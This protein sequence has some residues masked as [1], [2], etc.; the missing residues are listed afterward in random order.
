MSRK[1]VLMAGLLS[2]P[3]FAG[4]QFVPL[5]SLQED[6]SFGLFRN[7]TDAALTVDETVYGPGFS[8]L[9][10]D[11]LF[12]GLSNIAVGTP[13]GAL[14]T[15]PFAPDNP[16]WLG[17]YR[18]AGRPWSVFQ[19]IFFSDGPDRTTEVAHGDENVETVGL[20]DHIWFDTVTTTLRRGTPT[21]RLVTQTQF[22]ARIAPINLGAFFAV[23]RLDEVNPARNYVSTEV[24][25]YNTSVPGAVPVVETNYVVTRAETENDR[26]TEVVLG[27]PLFLPTEDPAHLFELELGWTRENLDTSLRV[28]HT[29]PQDPAHPDT[30][31][32]DEFVTDTYRTR[33]FTIA[34]AWTLI[35]P[36]LIGTNQNNRFAVGAGLDVTLHSATVVREELE[37]TY[38]FVPG[39]DATAIPGERHEVV[40]RAV[41]TGMMD[42]GL[43]ADVSH[44]I[45]YEPVD[46]LTYGFTPTLTIRYDRGQTDPHNVRRVVTVERVDNTDDG[47]FDDPADEIVT[48]TETYADSTLTGDRQVVSEIAF[49]F[50][51]PASVRIQPEGWSVG[52][53]L[54]SALSASMTR[55]STTTYQGHLAGERLRVVDGTGQ[56]IS[57]AAA[58]YEVDY[59][60]GRAISHAWSFQADH[61][62]GLHVLLPA[63]ARLDVVVRLANLLEFGSLGVQATVPLN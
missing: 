2:L 25:Q 11:Y 58:I 31:H 3:L 49:G 29:V 61:S 21:E 1:I 36:G 38:L 18:A 8:Q 55:T 17:Y 19:G 7:E 35:F 14:G 44:S 4:A 10:A 62:L 9:D 45:Y 50:A 22:L 6:V 27:L 20:T 23:D 56:V 30:S 33:S 54:G 59:A 28:E 24:H 34:P 16:L 51:L 47:A 60:P 42:L 39:P 13:E 32:V 12:A 41:V 26:R 52:F 63:D 57:D 40:E 15:F 48:R 46:A 43:S 37:Q 5:T 53:T